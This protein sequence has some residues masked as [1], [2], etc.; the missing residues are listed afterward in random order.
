M[1][2]AQFS[3]DITPD[4]D[5]DHKGKARKRAKLGYGKGSRNQVRNAA[6]RDGW[7]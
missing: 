2:H 5:A 3:A 6:A 7:I 1:T 4:Q